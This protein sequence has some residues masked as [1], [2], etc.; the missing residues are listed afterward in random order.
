VASVLY[1]RKMGILA[2]VDA[3]KKTCF[4]LAARLGT[5][6]STSNTICKNRKD[7]EKRYTKCGRF[8]GQFKEM[9]SQQC[10]I[11]DIY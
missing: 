9:K 6:L 4:P 11:T 3:N 2:Q 7:I 5:V 8:S 1:S 10:Y